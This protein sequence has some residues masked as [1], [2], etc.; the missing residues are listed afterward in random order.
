M[1]SELVGMG[2]K[3]N[4]GLV[5]QSH[6]RY[7]PAREESAAAGTYSMPM[8]SVGGGHGMGNH[9]DERLI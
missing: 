8:T 4:T 6:S 5:Q 2:N 7:N 9:K 3:C 1:E